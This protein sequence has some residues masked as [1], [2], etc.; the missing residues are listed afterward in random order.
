M[1]HAR[2]NIVVLISGNGSNLQAI[3]DRVGKTDTMGQVVAVISNEASAY[4]LERARLADVP[5]VTVS[6]ND[7]ETRD[8]YDAALKQKI[9][10]FSPDLVVLAGFMRIL[11]DDFVAHYHGRMLNIHPSISQPRIRFQ[12]I[13]CHPNMPCCLSS[14]IDP[15]KTS[16]QQ[17]DRY[18]FPVAELGLPARQAYLLKKQVP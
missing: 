16:L 12:V 6:H 10:E 17:G 8:A 3:L 2:K 5:A 11:T 15:D 7:Y 1:T 18:F 4:G 13:V 14:L 9:D